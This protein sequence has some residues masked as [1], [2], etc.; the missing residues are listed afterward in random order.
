MALIC[1]TSGVYAL[2]D[3]DDAH[4]E[5]TAELIKAETGPLL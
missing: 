5:P 1:D 3:T 4:H 2:Y